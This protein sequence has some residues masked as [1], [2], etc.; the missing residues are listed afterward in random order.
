[1]PEAV[2]MSGVVV[3]SASVIGVRSFWPRKL[4][5]PDQRERWLRQGGH[6]RRRHLRRP[7][8]PAVPRRR[9][10]AVQLEDAQVLR[11]TVSGPT[12]RP[13]RHRRCRTCDA[14]GARPHSDDLLRV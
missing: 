2:H 1:M 3:L 10:L 4:R 12:A 6:R 5:Q 7:G 13:R 11:R 14:R 8:G 9:L